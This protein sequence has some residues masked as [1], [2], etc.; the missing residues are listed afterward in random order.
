MVFFEEKFL[1]EAPPYQEAL[2]RAGY[3][4][5][6]KY[7][8][9]TTK[10]TRGRNILYYTPPF[11][12]AL[13]T[14]MTAAFNQ[15]VKKHFPRGS[16]LSK[17][18]NPNCLKISYSTTANMAALIS[19][20]NKKILANHGKTKKEL[21]L[22]N[23]RDGPPQ[24]PANGECQRKDVVYSGHVD[25]PDKPHLSKT[26]VGLTST[27]FKERWRNHKSSV[28]NRESQQKPPSPPTSGPS[29]IRAFSQPQPSH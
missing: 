19:A 18:F 2:N 9:K 24:C 17:I 27:T 13:T 28:E 12:K 14:N 16:V 15:L 3:S 8:E 29:K 22:C 23:C 26:Y 10:R 21:K 20:H 11:S 5:Q 7:E 4:H 1:E 25:V 6:L